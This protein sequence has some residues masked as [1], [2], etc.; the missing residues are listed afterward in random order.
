MSN[1]KVFLAKNILAS[2]FD[3]E[4]VKSSLLRI[5]G[6]DIVEAGMGISPS[7]CE[8][9]VIVAD[10]DFV[11]IDDES[12]S[13]SKNVA[14]DLKEFLKNSK[15]SLAFESVYVYSHQDDVEDWDDAET[16]YARVL[17][18]NDNDVIITN[19]DDY[20]HYAQI[21]VY[22]EEM[23]LLSPIS[24]DIGV[25]STIW[26][27]ISRHH[28]PKPEFAL[29][30]IPTMEERRL[31]KAPDNVFDVDALQQRICEINGD[32][33]RLLLLRK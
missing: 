5:P 4:Y 16:T 9:F 27:T 10:D 12:L 6:I 31:K 29:P 8:A 23:S 13:L 14:K 30:P 11:L 32:R 26:P 15:I 33:R 24:F 20:N 22:D 1:K 3:V 19:K 28:Q 18:L 7:E 25:D 21:G 2:G 17:S